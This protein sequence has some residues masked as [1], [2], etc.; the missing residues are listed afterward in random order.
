MQ[1]QQDDPL[2]QI[3][4]LLINEKFEDVLI[5]S[6]NLVLPDSKKAELY[7]IRGSIQGIIQA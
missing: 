1:A 6:E 3:R 4:L 2:S 7:Y 5:M